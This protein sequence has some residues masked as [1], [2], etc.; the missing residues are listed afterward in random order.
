[1]NG[2]GQAVECIDWQFT[3]DLSSATNKDNGR[4]VDFTRAERALL[5]VFVGH[6]DHVFSRDHLLDA[7]S[8]H[9]SDVSDRSI[10]FIINRLRRKLG[11]SARQPRYIQTRYGQGYVWIASATS[12]ERPSAGAFVVVGPLRGLEYVFHH[13]HTARAF[14]QNLAQAMDRQTACGEHICVDTECPLP[15]RFHGTPPRFAVE[16]SFFERNE[17]R[18]D[19]AIA[20]RDFTSRTVLH[21]TR[22]HIGAAG[23]T[24]SHA[25][26]AARI[27][28]ELFDRL[29]QVMNYST[30][31]TPAPEDEP[32]PV[33]LH[34][35]TEAFAMTREGWQEAETRLREQL[36]NAPED[37]EAQLKLATT[38]HSKYVISG[39]SVL[40]EADPRSA[41]EAE[42]E[43]LVTTALP[44]IQHNDIFRLMAAKLLYFVN[45]SHR[46]LALELAETAFERTA[47]FASAFAT[48][49]QLSAW[50]GDIDTALALYERGLALAT[51]GT[52][53]DLYLRVLQ[54]DALAAADRRA[55]A[56]NAATRM[57][58]VEPATRRSVG[59]FFAPNAEIDL[60]A[61]ISA[62]LAGMNE[63]RARALILKKHYLGG[64]MYRQP[65]HRCNSMR[66]LAEILT[67]HFGPR[68]IP[69]EAIDDLPDDCRP[70]RRPSGHRDC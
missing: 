32:L 2:S 44:H 18:L 62:M 45:P 59:L 53:F 9:G 16:L 39:D 40:M 63:A 30:A 70:G 3:D 64:R 26:T 58:K 51:P 19:C 22:V 69:P 60:T 5:E 49:G 48:V 20:L 14:A 15:T 42:I 68:C 27:A 13:E 25:G 43:R 41:D 37:H 1:M 33:R 23:E 61:D 66:R 7:I 24:T 8:G 65:A 21:I 36:R 57:Y 67:S 56:A 6:K 11:D 12:A 34:A 31:Q 50:E 52:H 35:S 10:D 55:A 4:Q 47:G 17:Q 38:L 29:W 54:C 46:T 28:R